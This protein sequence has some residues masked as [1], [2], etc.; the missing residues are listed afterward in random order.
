[1]FRFDES[2]HCSG[3]FRILG[4]RAIFVAGEYVFRSAEKTL[5]RAR[6]CCN[7]MDIA[8][9]LASVPMYD[10]PEISTATDA[11]WA[12]IARHAGLSFPLSRATD[13]A[14]LWRRDDLIFSQTCGYLFT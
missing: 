1:M 7:F 12:G 10:W 14:E 13:Y 11:W 9:M 4:F 2:A 6:F 8:R 5:R 3:L